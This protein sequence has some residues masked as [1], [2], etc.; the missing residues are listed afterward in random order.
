VSSSVRALLIPKRSHAYGQDFLSNAIAK[1]CN[2]TRIRSYEHLAK[3]RSSVFVVS[4]NPDSS[5]DCTL[6]ESLGHDSVVVVHVHCQFQFYDDAQ[7]ANLT[8]CMKRACVA[9]TPAPFLTSDMALRFPAVDWHTLYNGID[10]A[11]FFPSSSAER[12]TWRT[13]QRIP[14]D[15]LLVSIVGRLESAK[16]LEILKAF[17]RLLHDTK[18]HV[19]IQYLANSDNKTVQ[20]YHTIANDLRTTSPGRVHLFPDTNPSASR[21]IRYCDALLTPSLSEVCPL[22]VLEALHSGLQ[23]FG[24]DSTPFYRDLPTLGIPPSS[25]NFISIPPAVNTSLPRAELSVSDGIA[26]DLAQQLV[27]IA[28]AFD[29]RNDEQRRAASLCASQTVLTQERMLRQLTGIYDS[30]ANPRA[31]KS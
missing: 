13:R 21:P 4:Q 15:A 28:Q 5:D 10:T 22:V 7:R 18:V 11:R 8:R 27:A 9:I 31:F 24:T 30:A 3:R 2:L 25:Y 14:A 17:C 20:R 12:S 6:V 29:V 26:Q 1:Q 16:G 19:L 23:V